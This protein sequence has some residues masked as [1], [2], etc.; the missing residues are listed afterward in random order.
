MPDT[1]FEKQAHI[2]LN[3]VKA[4]LE[5]AGSNMDCLL[6]VTV[7]LK[8]QTKWKNSIEFIKPISPHQKYILREQEFRRGELRWIVALRLRQL[9]SSLECKCDVI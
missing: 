3:H 7:F 4:L 6:K 8:D 9:V 5:E 2:A 1:P